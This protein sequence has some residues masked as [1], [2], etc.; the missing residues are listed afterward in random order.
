MTA[1]Q[2]AT[3]A[4][5][6]QLGSLRWTELYRPAPPRR[7][8]PGPLREAL[9]AAAQGRLRQGDRVGICVG[10]RGIDG[11]AQVVGL[12]VEAVKAADAVP[13]VIPA[14]GSHGGATPQG[15]LAV[16]RDLGVREETL[17]VPFEASMEVE[18]VG[19]VPG[20]H[21][22]YLSAVALG[23]QAIVP[24]NR[25][26]PHSDFRARVESGLTKMLTIG[27]GKELGASSL[28]RAGFMAFGTV[29]P[30]A[31]EI[32]LSNLHVPFG[33][34]LVED[35]WHRLDR[36]EIVPGGSVLERDAQ[37][38]E[39][40]WGLFG[41]LPFGELDVLVLKEM[42]KTI[43]GAGMDPN[44]TG[45]FPV[46]PLPS[47]TKVARLVVLDLRDDSG[48]NAIGV[49]T[50]D[51]VTERLRNKVN[52]HYTYANARASKSLPGARL[53]MVATSDREAISDA[54][55]SLVGGRSGVPR[56]VAM[57]NTLEV[58]HLLVTGPLVS[59]AEPAGYHA[60]GRDLSAMFDKDGALVRIGDVPF[61]GQH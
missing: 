34:A 20:G 51:V 9:I 6:E 46:D 39:Q 2:V 48:G 54:L 41:S 18:Q 16:L 35:T 26:K 10:S 11:L 21:P 15:Q 19:V 7:F 45:R 43:S 36:A 24:V 13:V 60:A 14:M 29:L 47:P 25:V 22:V 50:A 12:V 58:N 1:T 52:W 8:D 44:V 32:V 42:G 28:H 59:E 23:C 56:V 4:E 49:G 33:V 37:L 38:L 55:G 31:L 3:P 40:A 61:F 57:A 27:L 30:A 5:V 17:G 53:P